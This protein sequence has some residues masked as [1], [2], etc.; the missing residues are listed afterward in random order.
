M[1]WVD[2]E[3]FG[4]NAAKDPL[5]EIGFKITDLDL[6]IIDEQ[7]W[8]VWNDLSNARHEQMMHAAEHGNPNA[9]YVL[10]MHT[11]NGLFSD[12][13]ENGLSVEEAERE[14]LKFL[15]DQNDVLRD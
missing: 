15:V 14:M 3:S 11:N 7:D 9:K 4:L 5:I 6:Y 1:I 2:V 10:E 12:A 13:K 8:V